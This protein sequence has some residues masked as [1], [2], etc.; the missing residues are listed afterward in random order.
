MKGMTAAAFLIV[1]GVCTC[2]R[3]DTLVSGSVFD[4]DLSGNSSMASGASSNSLSLADGSPQPSQEGYASLN[5]NV[6]ATSGTVSA[7]GESSQAWGLF[8]W[9]TSVGSA[10]YDLSVNGTYEMTGGTGY[11]YADLTVLSDDFYDSG[12]LTCSI[13]FDGQTQDCA[14]GSPTPF[15]VP[16]NTPLNLNFDASYQGTAN[17]NGFYDTLSY[18]FAAVSPVPEPSSL[19]LLGTGLVALVGTARRRA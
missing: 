1:I 2:A 16:Y 14:Y 19:L 3:G 13:T 9:A 18:N 11:G 8:G 12:Y 7:L 4:Q 15:Y 5:A 10:S 17:V 6:G